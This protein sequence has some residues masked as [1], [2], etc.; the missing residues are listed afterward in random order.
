M[1]TQVIHR[2]D[3]IF[4][5]QPVFVGTRVPLAFLFDYLKDGESIDTFISDFPTVK[6]EAAIAALEI[7]EMSATSKR[8]VTWAP[9]CYRR[10][11][12]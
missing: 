5:G 3:E 7:A 2:D 1:D 8:P 6:K 10:A 11:G 4:G 9:S 12:K